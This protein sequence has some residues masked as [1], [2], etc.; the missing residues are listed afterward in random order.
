MIVW[1]PFAV[2]PLVAFLIHALILA[3]LL[4]VKRKEPVVRFFGFYLFFMLAWTA[5]AV[6]WRLISS[7]RQSPSATQVLGFGLIQPVLYYHFSLLYLQ[8]SIR[9]PKL[10]AGYAITS[11]VWVLGL[12]GWPARM[13]VV[14][15]GRI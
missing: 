4:R 2:V 12:I 15:D 13:I 10:W 7:L 9:T 5:Y 14:V 8:K 3:V 1:D 11:I 6:S